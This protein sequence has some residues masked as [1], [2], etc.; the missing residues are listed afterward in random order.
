MITGLIGAGAVGSSLLYFGAEKGHAIVVLG[1]PDRLEKYKKG[2]RINGRDIAVQVQEKK[3]QPLDILF[4][5]VKS[6]DFEQQ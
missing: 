4:L 5:S 6:I 1:D 3:D 2:I